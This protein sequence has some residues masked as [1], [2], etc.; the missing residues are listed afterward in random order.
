MSL[1]SCVA[2]TA[3][4][5]I[6]HRFPALARWANFCRA[7]GPEF[8]LRRTLDAQAAV[9]NHEQRR[10]RIKKLAQGVRGCYETLDV[11]KQNEKM[12]AGARITGWR[13]SKV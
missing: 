6:Y 8:L 4:E 7:S 1:L 2:P 10:R 13:I 9:H 5:I 3:L 11:A 12:Q